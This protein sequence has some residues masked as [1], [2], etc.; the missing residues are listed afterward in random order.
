MCPVFIFSNS[1]SPWAPSVRPLHPTGHQNSPSQGH[2]WCG[3]WF[4]QDCPGSYPLT[5]LSDY[6]LGSLSLSKVF[7]F[8]WW[9]IIFLVV[10]T[11]MVHSAL[12]HPWLALSLMA[13]VIC[14]FSVFP[15]GRK[16]L[17]W[18]HSSVINFINFPRSSTF[19]SSTVPV[20]VLSVDLIISHLAFL[21]SHPH[22]CN[23]HAYVKY[24]IRPE[25]R[26]WIYLL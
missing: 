9:I 15:K 22:P 8:E 1:I 19:I 18:G 3:F 11:N 5:W 4:V 7:W 25:A 16:S 10:T 26:H 21:S 23:P 13:C 2:Q 12:T 6:E 17:S 20:A 24:R 14:A